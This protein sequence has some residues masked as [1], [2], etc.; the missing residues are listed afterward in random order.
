M[1][2][3]QTLIQNTP[4]LLRSFGPLEYLD[5]LQEQEL[6]YLLKTLAMCIST[7]LFIFP[8]RN[9]MLNLWAHL[10]SVKFF[11]IVPFWMYMSNIWYSTSSLFFIFLFFFTAT[12]ADGFA[13]Y[14]L[15][16]CNNVS[17]FC[18]G[19]VDTCWKVFSGYWH[20][21]IYSNWSV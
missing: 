11:R 10:Y 4:L 7:L 17:I 19:W 21:E 1:T 18:S 20:W 8:P 16:E 5:L 6:L 9:A 3:V 12:K 15:G 14:F 2:L 13:L